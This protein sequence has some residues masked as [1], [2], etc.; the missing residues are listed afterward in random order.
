M[1][2]ESQEECVTRGELTT[3]DKILIYGG[4]IAFFLLFGGHMAYEWG[5][6]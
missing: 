5:L 2:S 1:A 6:I 3:V 4:Y